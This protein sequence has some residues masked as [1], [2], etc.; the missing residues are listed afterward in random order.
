[1]SNSNVYRI[2]TSIVSAA[3]IKAVGEIQVTKKWNETTKQT[4]KER[5]VLIPFE[6]VKAP[7]VQEQFRALVEAAL[8][9]QAVETLKDFCDA[10]PNSFEI[11]A[12]QFERQTLVDS[13]LTRGDS[14]MTKQELEIAF[15]ASATWKRI[16]ESEKFK[17]N[18]AYKNA[19]AAYKETILKLCGKNVSFTVEKCD[20]ILA[21]FEETDLE[22][23]FGA[24]VVKRV[25]AIRAKSSEVAD[26]DAL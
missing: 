8:L 16:T 24:F 1:M 14:W 7:E 12:D 15:T 26:F 17:E 10:N 3:A 18:Q 22:T 9:S 25:N 23:E 11:G 13:F 19:A 21:K 4:A 5:S 20:N 6:C 2:H